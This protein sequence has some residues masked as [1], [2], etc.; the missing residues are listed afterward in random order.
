[1]FHPELN[2]FCTPSQ[3]SWLLVEF[4]ESNM[5]RSGKLIR[6]QD[7]H[8]M[9]RA[10]ELLS[11]CWFFLTRDRRFILFYIPVYFEY[12]MNFTYV[13]AFFTHWIISQLHADLWILKSWHLFLCISFNF[14]LYMVRS[15]QSRP[16]ISYLDTF[17]LLSSPNVG[18]CFG[19]DRPTS[20]CHIFYFW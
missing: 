18:Y 11:C 1:M 8:K 2:A 5:T 9:V 12:R 7:V 19:T 3:N 6:E 14:Y 13:V 16:S 20:N 17:V 4:P 15:S 10:L